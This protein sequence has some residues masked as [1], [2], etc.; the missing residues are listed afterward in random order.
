MPRDR[1]HCLPATLPIVDGVATGACKSMTAVQTVPDASFTV[2]VTSC[3][4]FDLLA[5]SLR[6]LRD[7]LDVDPAA[8]IIVEDSDDEGARQCA[9]DA[10]LDATIIINGRQM[11]QMP[12]IDRAYSEVRTPYVFHSEDDWLFYRNGFIR[13]SL[14][15]LSAFPEISTVGLRSRDDQNPLVR[16]M[17]QRMHEG[18]AYYVLDPRLHPEYF[19]YGF[20]PGLRRMADYRALG[21]FA[22]LGHEADVSYAF[23][24]RGFAMANLED[25]AVRH[26][27]D[28]RHVND[29]S[30]PPKAKTLPQKLLR[31]IRKRWKR[32]RRAINNE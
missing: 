32:I 31:S 22:R 15:I 12:S 17:P 27:G 19:S 30:F 8:W 13:E 10:G 24:R 2:V 29:P 4:R 14:T 5:L 21:P 25:H 18:V 6:S 9:R 23:K 7:C 16:G 20:N 28:N 26:I 11:G 1:L 3:R